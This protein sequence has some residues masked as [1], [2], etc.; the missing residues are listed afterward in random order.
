MACD[1]IYAHETFYFNHIDTDK[2]P[3][4]KLPTYKNRTRFKQWSH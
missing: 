4:Y 1:V 3:E 2:I